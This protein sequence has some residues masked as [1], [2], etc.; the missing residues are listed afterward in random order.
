MTDEYLDLGQQI[1]EIENFHEEW[2][3]VEEYY[4]QG[5][6]GE[7]DEP[8]HERLCRRAEA[9]IEA[10]FE[11]LELRDR[12]TMGDASPNEVHLLLLAI[13]AEVALNAVMMR[14][15][16]NYFVERA[17]VEEG[18]TPSLDDGISWVM[19]QL[20]ERFGN[21]ERA[22]V[23][24]TLRLLR[25]HRNNSAHLGYQRF[26]NWRHYRE[27]YRVLAFLFDHYFEESEI[28]G[29]LAQRVAKH[30]EHISPDALDYPPVD[31]GVDSPR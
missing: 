23:S 25:V 8:P 4:D 10:S 26:T 28:I 2:V 3:K 15:D 30:R 18:R 21:E 6:P 5:N 17:S 12:S 24:Q 11:H 7:F 29:E 9:L 31:L 13:A 20:P 19:P 22:R 14:E 1:D 27:I 16:W